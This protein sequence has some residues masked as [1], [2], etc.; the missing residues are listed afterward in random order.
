M[1]TILFL[2][3]QSWFGG[4]QRV[5][6]AVI[7]SL[8]PGRFHPIVAF[9]GPGPFREELAR[10]GIETITMPLGD[11]A[12][13]RKSF[14]ETVAFAFRSALCC[15]RLAAII[16]RRKVSLVYING[17]RCLPAGVLA[18][19]LT[20]RPSLF[21]LQLILTRKYEALLAS[22][23]SRYVSNVVA[24][25]NAAAASLR[26]VDQRLSGKMEVLYNPVPDPDVADEVLETDFQSG[27][28]C[29]TLGM[30]GRITETKGQY[31]LLDAVARLS[32]QTRECLRILI[33]G[34]PAPGCRADLRYVEY[35]QE[36]ALRHDLDRRI[37]WAG[38]Q[39][40]PGPAYRSMDVLVHPAVAEAMGLVILEAF[41]R[42]VP[43]IAARTGGIPEI[44]D[45]GSNGL[46]VTPGN[47]EELSRALSLFVSDESLRE[48]LKA[49]ARSGL[50]ERFSLKTFSARIRILVEQLCREPRSKEPEAAGREPAA[51]N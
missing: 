44:V 48:R 34:A 10:H 37:V 22:W 23:L 50:A 42:G 9:P 18:A 24:C 11:Y 27:K 31:L 38:Y 7:A 29:L 45:E 25:S 30:V 46:L 41:Q 6:Q 14:L 19:S 51:W 16:R 39:A 15:A 40:D 13:G 36:L 2:E 28:G 32:P 26:S 43:V 5:L 8:P 47:E 20:G 4:A 12:S 17:P 35:L 21:H 33:V 1:K 49:G 3:Q